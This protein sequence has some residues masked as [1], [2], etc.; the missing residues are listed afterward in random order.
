M[1]ST[2]LSDDTTVVEEPAVLLAAS[3]EEADDILSSLREL[4][5]RGTLLF[6]FVD[7]VLCLSLLP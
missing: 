2:L 3:A 7:M 4:A 1:L 6:Q 5:V